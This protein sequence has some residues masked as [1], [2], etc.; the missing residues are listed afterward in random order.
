MALTIFMLRALDKPSL[1]KIHEID[2][3]KAVAAYAQSRGW[4]VGYTRQS[5]HMG[6]DGKWRGSG[7]KGEPDLRLVRDGRVLF[8]EL[9][10][11]SGS[12]SPEQKE[13]LAALGD[14]GRMWKPRDSAAIIEELE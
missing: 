9:K 2:F 5:G 4:L 10:A 6:S 14:L 13:W 12:T 11:E 3:S 8:A 1:K 7:P